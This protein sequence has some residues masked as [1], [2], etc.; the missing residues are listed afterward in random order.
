M[1]EPK[2]Q[3]RASALAD[4]LYR[5]IL[6]SGLREGELFMTGDNVALRYHVS[7]TVAREALSQLRALGVLK[8]RQRKGLLVARPDP[9]ELT[10]RWVPLYGHPA[11]PEAFRTLA[12]LR[13]V[14]E[15]GALDLAVSHAT[16]AQIDRLAA[17]ARDFERLAGGFGHTAETDAIDLAFH[18]AILE[19]T[20][21]PLIAGMH[22]ILASYFQASIDFDPRPD[23]SKAIREHHSIADAFRRRDPETVR[24]LMRTH[25]EAMRGT[26]P[27][28]D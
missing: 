21:N 15:I 27:G 22:R 10:A 13:Y 2:R 17:L 7:R 18:K 23:A 28:H 24:A 14:L 3:T 8:S 6:D 1:A 16:D 5:D 11:N 12:Q 4:T 9:L 19:M 20:G 26:E 25:L